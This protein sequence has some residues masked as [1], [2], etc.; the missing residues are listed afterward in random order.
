MLARKKPWSRPAPLIAK[1]TGERIDDKGPQRNG[2]WLDR[3]RSL[4]CLCCGHGRQQHPTR[5][6]HPKGLFPR[7]MGVRI[8]DLLCLP[9]CDYHHTDAPGA[10]HRSGDELHWW[11]SMGA[12]PYG[13]ILS[14]LAG[15]RD[16]GRDEAIAFVKLHR[17]RN[18]G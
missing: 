10:L 1:I 3:I 14:C 17:E 8:S 9:L 15:C 5:A 4:P 12:E 11:R 16:P 6:H 13:C 2:A 18:A 7:T